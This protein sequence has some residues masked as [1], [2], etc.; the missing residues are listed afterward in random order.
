MGTKAD[1]PGQKGQFWLA[2]PLINGSLDVVFGQPWQVSYL[3]GLQQGPM[4]AEQYRLS[5]NRMFPI[6]NVNSDLTYGLTSTI[7]KTSLTK[8]LT[9]HLICELAMVR[10]AIP[11]RSGIAQGEETL[12][13]RYGVSF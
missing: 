11:V 10:G 4:D 9:D 5:L 12:H 7:I 1:I 8:Q 3:G 6:L 13:F 2:T